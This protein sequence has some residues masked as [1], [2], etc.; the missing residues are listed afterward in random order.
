M[1]QK[2]LESTIFQRLAS[3]PIC[4]LLY[5]KLFE[6]EK[7]QQKDFFSGVA[8][9]KLVADDFRC[10]INVVMR[11]GPSAIEVIEPEEIHL[12]S[13]EMHSLIAD[14][15][16]LTQVF[17]SQITAMMKDDE[18]RLLYQKMLDKKE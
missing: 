4:H 9:V 8:E 1:A 3:E 6:L 7:D 12:N 13:D 14:I 10:F 11:Y 17:T 5:A 16:E 18:R 15:S 2:A